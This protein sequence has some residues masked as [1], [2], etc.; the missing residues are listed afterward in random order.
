MRGALVGL[1]FAVG[2]GCVGMGLKRQFRQAYQCNDKVS[3]ERLAGG[4]YQVN[5][6]QKTA[7]YDCNGGACVVTNTD[8]A[9]YSEVVSVAP[10]QE[11]RPR[12]AS[13]RRIKLKDGLTIVDLKLP[14]DGKTWLLLRASPERYG[15][16]VQV[17]LRRV[18]AHEDLEACKLDWMINGQRLDAPEVRV[19]AKPPQSTIRGNVPR[20]IV[21]EL[22][23]AEQFAIKACDEKWTLEPPQLVEIRKFV[24]LYEE[25]LAWQGDARDGGA[26]GLVAPAGGWPKWEAFGERPAQAEAKALSG[27]QLFKLLAP[28]VFQLE[29]QS[30][31]GTAQGSAVAVTEDELLTNC[32]VLEGARRV[33]V[34][35]GDAESIGTITRA[36]PKSDRCVVSV[37]GR[38]LQPIA[39]VRGRAELEVGE[40]LFTLGSPSGLELTLGDGILSGLRQVKERT[41]VQ[42]SAPISPGSS[43]GGLFDA[44]GNLVGITTLVLA[45]RERLNQSLNFAIPAE[46]FFEP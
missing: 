44:H 36:D 9:T 17:S 14:L 30:A 23:M 18:S 1:S 2:V 24:E 6:C 25:E 13:A 20:A 42:T 3:V 19:A 41:F 40:P 26:V 37:K 29:V 33:I 11:A 31:G 21:R 27:S 39:G 4:M 34:K 43:G 15:D 35:K 22:G 45:G 38:K 8:D 7:T 16:L 28:S 46:S 32:H 10:R 5:G 12:R